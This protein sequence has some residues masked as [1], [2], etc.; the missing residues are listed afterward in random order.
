MG[1][2][3]CIDVVALRGNKTS[4]SVRVDSQIMVENNN[5]ANS[6]EKSAQKWSIANL[7]FV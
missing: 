4:P 6:R 1:L 2:L 7:L 5:L 3:T